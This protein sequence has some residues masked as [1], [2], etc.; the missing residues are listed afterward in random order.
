MPNCCGGSW[1]AIPAPVEPRFTYYSLISINN[2]HLEHA[3]GPKPIFPILK[4]GRNFFQPS[5][6]RLHQGVQ[7]TGLGPEKFL[8]KYWSLIQATV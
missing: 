6:R 4:T 2:Q 5:S 3:Q 1:K 8:K 7:A